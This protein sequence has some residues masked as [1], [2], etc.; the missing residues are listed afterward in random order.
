[1]IA[2]MSR[3]KTER[4]NLVGYSCGSP[5]LA[6]ALV[7]LRARYPE[8]PPDAIRRRFRIGNVIFA[9]SD[10]DVK[11]F[12]RDAFP[13]VK[14]LATQIVVY[15]SKNDGA[16]AFS[17]LLAGTSRVGKP[18]IYDLTREDLD[19]FAADSR[20]EMVDV[21]DVRGAHELGGMKGHGYWFANDWISSDVTICMRYP[22]PAKRRCLQSGPSRNTWRLPEDYPDC[23]VNRLLETYPDV[24][25]T[26]VP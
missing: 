12:A 25:R 24:G 15:I 6:E 23:L 7:R 4:L 19:A 14:D 18:D 8:E 16:L 5:L 11:T 2:L 1:V 21:T 26:S 10:I 20:F 17:S 13:S 3:T 9:A 22:I